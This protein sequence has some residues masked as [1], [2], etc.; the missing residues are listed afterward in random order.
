MNYSGLHVDYKEFL[1]LLLVTLIIV[2]YSYL[3][4]KY[5]VKEDSILHFKYPVLY[6]IVLNNIYLS[7]LLLRNTRYTIEKLVYRY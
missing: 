7:Y 4:E 3:L 2:L 1:L 6:I 5:K